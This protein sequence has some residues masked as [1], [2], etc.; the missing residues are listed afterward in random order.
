MEE[1][2]VEMGVRVKVGVGVEGKSPAPLSHPA[3]RSLAVKLAETKVGQI[4]ASQF[5]DPLLF[6]RNTTIIPV[7]FM[8]V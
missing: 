5:P 6:T 2:V 3:V 4:R 1:G 8:R 7:C